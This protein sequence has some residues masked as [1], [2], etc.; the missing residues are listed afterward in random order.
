[1]TTVFIVHLFIYFLFY[2]Y[3]ILF[4]FYYYFYIFIYFIFYLFIFFCDLTVPHLTDHGRL[5][6][7]TVANEVLTCKKQSLTV[8]VHPSR[9]AVWPLEILQGPEVR[10]RYIWN[11]WKYCVGDV[12]TAWYT[13]DGRKATEWTLRSVAVYCMVYCVVLIGQNLM[14]WICSAT[15]RYQILTVNNIVQ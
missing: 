7:T 6:P 13:A 1:M 12:L 8:S 10:K 11:N 4:L 9:Y 15:L 14:E 5:L 2:F 3:F